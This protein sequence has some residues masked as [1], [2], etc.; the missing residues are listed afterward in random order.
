MNNVKPKKILKI[1]ITRNSIWNS[2]ENRQFG[3]SMIL[4]MEYLLKPFLFQMLSKSWLTALLTVK[5]TKNPDLKQ[6]FTMILL[7]RLRNWRLVFIRWRLVMLSEY[8]MLKTRPACTKANIGINLALSTDY[9]Y[10]SWTSVDRRKSLD[11]RP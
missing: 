3:E 11:I 6:T 10:T 9:R 8:Y 1:R 5:S 4:Y 7:V 2:F